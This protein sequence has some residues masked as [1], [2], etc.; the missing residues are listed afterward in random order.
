MS[1]ITVYWALV[2]VFSLAIIAGIRLFYR[3]ADE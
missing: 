1:I 3:E 2:L